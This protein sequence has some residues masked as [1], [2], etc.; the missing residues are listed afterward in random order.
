MRASWEGRVVENVRR[1]DDVAVAVASF[2]V[3]RPAGRRN[4]DM[5][6][7]E[8]MRL[9]FWMGWLGWIGMW[10][11]HEKGDAVSGSSSVL[12]CF[13]QRCF[14]FQDTCSVPKLIQS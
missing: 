1:T 14:A 4:V 8:T 3:I 9:G 11:A 2:E 6:D 7:L 13:R 5:V 12:G 10:T